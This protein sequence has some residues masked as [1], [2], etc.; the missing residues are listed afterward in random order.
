MADPDRKGGGGLSLQTLAVASAA[1]LTA[2]MV[3]S[4]L[5]PPGTIYASALTPVLVAAISELLHRPADRVTELRRQRRTMVLEMHGVPSEQAEAEADAEL[6]RTEVRERSRRVHPKVWAA[7]GF[8]AFAIAAAVLTLPELIFGGA[9][10]TKHRTTFFGGGSAKSST[11]S[12]TTTTTTS[13]Q[14]QTAPTTV[15]ETVPAQTPPQSTDTTQ[16]DTTTTTTGTQ[17][18]PSGG[19]PAPGDTGTST[20]PGGVVVPPSN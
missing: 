13:T 16:T 19:A 11:P 17:T 12:K 10:A 15:T 20:T 4:R 18:A 1:S 14:T 2:A 6:G 9:V 3:T 5:F 7:T 8:A